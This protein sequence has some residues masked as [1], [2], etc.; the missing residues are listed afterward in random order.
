MRLRFDA[1][2]ET[3]FHQRRDELA[4]QFAR[5]LET[6]RVTGEPSDAELLMDWKFRCGDGALDCWTTADAEEFLFEWCPRKL[7]ASPADSA[8]IPGSVA[9]FVEFLAHAGFLAPGSGRPSDIRRVCER[10]TNRFVREMGNPA[11]FGMAKNVFAGASPSDGEAHVE[12]IS[13]LLDQL[14]GQSPDAVRELLTGTD[15]DEELARTVGPVRLPEPDER[16]SAIRAAEDMRLLRRLAEQCPQ[17]GRQLTAKGNLRLADARALVEAIGTGDHVDRVRTAQDVPVLG[18]VVALGVAAGV[19]RRHRGRLVAVATFATLDDV[20]AHEKVVRAALEVGLSAPSGYGID[21]DMHRVADSS[22]V[23][24]LAELLDAG[25]VGVEVDDL[26]D[27]MQHLMSGAF[28]LSP[29]TQRLIPVWLDAQLDRLEQ[30]GVLTLAD[31]EAECL[32]CEQQH[33]IARLTAAGVPIA[34]DLVREIGI[35]VTVR[36]DPTG[37]DAAD[38]ADLIGEI[39]PEEWHA[40]AS[41]WFAA[42]PTPAEA[43]DRLITEITAEHREPVTVL[44]GLQTVPDVVG[45]LA[46]PAV[47]RQLGGPHDGLVLHWLSNHAELDP[48]SVDPARLIAGL[49]DVLAAALDI[50]GPQDVLLFL[51]DEEDTLPRLIDSLWR[52]D[53]PRVATCSRRLGRTTPPSPSPRRRGRR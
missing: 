25:S 9:A 41:A 28:P 47:R 31:G 24:L 53:H 26:F 16:L 6:H 42:Q 49:V 5:W 13:A 40:D 35:Q 34:V 33:Q 51:E 22:V 12:A 46:V 45:D 18:R 21:G 52:M 2:D 32:D 30:L 50:G 36:T 48:E 4:G 43:A 7:A 17:P 20:A 23:V 19:V 29:L 44:I 1:D 37:A 10:G 38:I 27:L 15:D 8:E 14:T 39:P 11:N 3:A